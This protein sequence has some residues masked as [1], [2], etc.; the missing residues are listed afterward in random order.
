MEGTTDTDFFSEFTTKFFSYIEQG[1]RIVVTSHISPDDDSIGSVLVMRT[2]LKERFP[3]KS[4]SIIYTGEKVARYSVFS[5]FDSIEWVDD[6]A[7]HLDNVDVLITVDASNW[8]RFSKQPEKLAM[9]PVRIGIDHHAS[10]PDEYTILCKE[11]SYVS[12]TQLVHDI[13]YNDVE[14]SKTVSEY[15]LLG[16]LGDTGNFSYVAP[17]QASVFLLG[18]TLV[19][20]IGMPIDQFRSRYGSIPKRILPLLQTLVKNTQY[21]SVKKWPDFQYTF[22]EREVLDQQFYTDEDMSAASHIY[23]GQYLSRIEGYAWGFVITPRADNTCR[24]SSRSLP[25]SV[26]VRDL[27][28][29]MNIGGGHDRASG[30]YFTEPNPASCVE[31][32]IDWMRDNEP[33][34][35]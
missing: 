29:R 2:L 20:K 28:E 19:E 34:I 12:T 17:K 4:I 24:M 32:V 5:D 31:I 11:E 22:I 21:G 1:K 33:L 14:Y 18:K 3:D 6:V 13:F 35:G 30:G 9:V 27:H 23:M 10:V 26:N 8:K 15:I 25:G 7:Q 16:L